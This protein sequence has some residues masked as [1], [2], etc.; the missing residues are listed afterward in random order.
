LAFAD[1]YGT[2]QE[3][4]KKTKED[5]MEEAKQLVKEGKKRVLLS[6]YWAHAGVLP[7][8]AESY[9]NFFSE[10]SELSNAF[11]L[12]KGKDLEKY[13]N[14]QV[15]ILGV[16]GDK[17]EYTVIPTEDAV[18]LLKKENKNA[19]IHQIKDCDHLFEGKEDA[20]SKI[21]IEFLNKII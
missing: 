11:P 18:E 1:T 15:P 19:E 21:V 3:Y 4:L 8:A 9:V 7:K 5:H 20:L 10:H 14:I 16:I 6:N 12:R 17:E 13:Q 2:H